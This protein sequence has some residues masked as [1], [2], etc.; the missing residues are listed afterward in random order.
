MSTTTE[1]PIQPA[2]RAAE[3]LE[4]QVQD[5]RALSAAHGRA[6]HEARPARDDAALELEA[7]RAQLAAAQAAYDAAAAVVADHDREAAAAADIADQVE[8]LAAQQR[9]RDTPHPA[10][11]LAGTVPD[12]D[13]LA[14]PPGLVRD[15]R[16]EVAARVTGG[17]PTVP[18]VPDAPDGDPAGRHRLLDRRRRT[19]PDGPPP[20]VL[21]A[22]HGP[23][24]TQPHDGPAPDGNPT[25]TRPDLEDDRG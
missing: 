14:G 12:A 10:V 21:V 16:A 22:D 2:Q 6:A 23:D 4:Q 13:P 15:A 7:A 24:V 11:A 3:L 5:L 19:A 9:E 17:H 18:T 20:G 25:T 1:P 8:T